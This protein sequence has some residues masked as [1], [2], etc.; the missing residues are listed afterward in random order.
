[1]EEVFCP[2]AANGLSLEEVWSYLPP[3][4]SFS[5]DT[6][7][8]NRWILRRKALGGAGAKSK[9]YGPRSACSDF[10]AMCFWLTYAWRKYEA[11]T[12][13]P[14]P[15]QFETG[16]ASCAAQALSQQPCVM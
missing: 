1:M 5:K 11:P 16:A 7:R 8:E 9:S 2:V 13:T 6:S 10:K 4:Y 15:W 3:G 14:C 12:G